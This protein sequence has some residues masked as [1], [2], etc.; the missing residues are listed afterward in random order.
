MG[1]HVRRPFDR[2]TAPPVHPRP[3]GE[4]DV[5]VLDARPRDRRHEQRVAEQQLVVGG[6]GRLV[7]RVVEQQRPQDRRAGARALLERA[8]EIRQQPHPQLQ[9]LADQPGPRLA[10][11]PRLLRHRLDVRVVA[12]ERLDDA[13]LGPARQQ[14]GVGVAVEAADVDA[15]ERHAR[16][17]EVLQ[18]RDRHPQVLPPRAV[19]A[20]PLQRVALQ[21]REARARDDERAAGRAAAAR[22]PRARHGPSASR[23]GCGPRRAAA[24][25]PC[26][27]ARRPRASS[28]ASG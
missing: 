21:P 20:R 12:A 6:V 19:V 1:E 2:L 24:A 3:L 23:R 10:E 26:R 7:R 9:R 28:T 4:V 15:A 25:P 11:A 16:E 13:E 18:L 22:A 5:A 8:V 17:P 14:L 27:G